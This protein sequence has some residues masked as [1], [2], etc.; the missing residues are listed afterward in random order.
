MEYDNSFNF[1]MGTTAKNDT[2]NWFDNPYIQP[3]VY[4][5]TEQFNPVE[6]NISMRLC[7]AKD[8]LDKIMDRNIEYFYT[9]TLCFSDKK[10]ISFL[11][12][13]FVSKYK[14]FW[15][16]YDACRNTTSNP[17]KCAPIE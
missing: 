8:D 12:S 15:V 10:A 4:D 16:S 13:W 9:N 3:K 5:V 14:N 2:F 7:D 11:G 1:I 6:S 17:T